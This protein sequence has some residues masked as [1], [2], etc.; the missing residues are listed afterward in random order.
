MRAEDKFQKY[1][2]KQRKA[3]DDVMVWLI[4]DIWT[5]L[6][7]NDC[8]FPRVSIKPKG[9]SVLLIVSCTQPG[10]KMVAFIQGDSILTAF[11][12]LRRRIQDQTMPWKEDKF[13]KEL[14]KAGK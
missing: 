11:Q 3:L 10:G 5:D 1:W 2:E 12:A 6:I 13:A 8:N 7:D 14:D 4:E 9:T